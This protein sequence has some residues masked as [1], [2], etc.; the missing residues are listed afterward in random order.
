MHNLY[1]LLQELDSSNIHYRLDRYRD[2]VVT[3]HVTVPGQRIEIDVESNGTVNTASFIGS[4]DLEQ[5]LEVVQKIVAEF[6]D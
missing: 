1:K 4:E 3:V 6:G 2:D 5:G